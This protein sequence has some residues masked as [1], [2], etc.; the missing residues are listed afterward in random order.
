MA[1]MNAARAPAGK[2]KSLEV[3]DASG[4]RTDPREPILAR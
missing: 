3:R 4:G 2:G 1:L